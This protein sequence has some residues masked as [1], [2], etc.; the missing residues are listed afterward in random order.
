MKIFILNMLL[1]SSFSASAMADY[2]VSFINHK[3]IVV[4]CPDNDNI[5]DITEAHSSIFSFVKGLSL[6]E[7]QEA[8]L[9][10]VEDDLFKEGYVSRGKFGSYSIFQREVTSDD[11]QSTVIF[12]KGAGVSTFIKPGGWSLTRDHYNV[13]ERNAFIEEVV[14][15]EGLSLEAI[16]NMPS[17]DIYFG[18]EIIIYKK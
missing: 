3:S 6:S 11:N 17:H 13:A 1:I 8:V 2:C 18:D 15:E 10:K 14:Q 4:H 9:T 7:R 16:I 12:K 5:A